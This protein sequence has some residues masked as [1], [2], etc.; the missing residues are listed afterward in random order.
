[1]KAS[2]STGHRDATIINVIPEHSLFDSVIDISLEN[3][4]AHAY[5]VLSASLKDEK[6]NPWF[7]S[8]AVFEA[9]E[10][11]I[12]GGILRF[13]LPAATLKIRIKLTSSIITNNSD[14]T[15]QVFV[16]HQRINP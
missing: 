1:M 13:V 2:S 11:G 10:H 12:V 8:E 4:P 16:N 9:N 6:G 14:Y 7:Y 15:H 3:L 5:V